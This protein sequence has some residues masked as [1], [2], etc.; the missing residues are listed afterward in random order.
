[1]TSI[2]GLKRPPLGFSRLPS[3]TDHP[4]LAEHRRSSD[5]PISKPLSHQSLDANGEFQVDNDSKA[6]RYSDLL[7]EIAMTTAFASLTEGTHIFEAWNVAS[8]LSFFALVWW[9][10]ASQVAYNVRFRRADWMHRLFVF[11]QFFVFCGLAAFTRDFD[12]TDGI[13]D[14]SQKENQADTLERQSFQDDQV[15]IPL[16]KA[17]K[18]RDNLLPKLNFRGI[19]IVMAL[20]RLLLLIQYS[21]AYYY[22]L[23]VKDTPHVTNS[24]TKNRWH[25]R[26]PAFI[27][28]MLSLLFS[29]ICF[30]VS[31]A[32]IGDNPKGDNQVAKLVLWY[33]PLFVEVAAHFVAISGRYKGWVGYSSELISERSATVFVIILGGGLDNI[34]NGFQ[35][36]VGNIS[37]GWRSLGVIFCGVLIFLLLF[38]LHFNTPK[39]ESSKRMRVLGAFFFQFFYLSAVIVNLEAIAAMLQAGTIGDGLDI[40]LQFLRE[41]ASI[42]ELKGFGRFLNES[43][44]S[45]P[46]VSK[47]LEKQGLELGVM[48]SSINFWIDNATNQNPPD[49]NLPYNSLL[50]YDEVIIEVVLQ[51]LD[52]YPDDDLLVAKMDAFYYSSPLNYTSVNNETFDDIIRSVII[53]NATPALWFYGSG[54]ALLLTLGV[55]CLISQRPRDKFEWGQI[56]SRILFGSFIIIL[57]SLDL[58]SSRNNIL[59]DD[60]HYGDSKIWYLA[61]HSLVLPPYAVALLIEHIIELILLKVARRFYPRQPTASTSSAESET[62]PLV[63]PTR[64]V[65]GNFANFINDVDFEKRDADVE[66]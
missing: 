19:S 27:V 15:A 66:A 31:Y 39:A 59:T 5:V 17:Q 22:A 8:Y 48:L 34:T 32:V 18:Y 44:Y 38:A 11:L 35:R 28:H 53:E 52:S 61:T 21:V 54:G 47:Q 63:G 40:P 30:F 13:K 20:S 26:Y 62:S 2:K 7:L 9:I 4:K 10:W 55:L 29:V 33:F 41:T 36:I 6:V 65:D 49:F 56:L 23:R 58:H 51:N 50:W 25:P 1:M 14:D 12:I 43:D 46:T 45:S 57:S 64:N 60:F 3:S 24:G 16:M 37:F 42:M